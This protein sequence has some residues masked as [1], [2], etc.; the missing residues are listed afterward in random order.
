MVTGSRNTHVILL[1]CR[2]PP[3]SPSLL[4][5]PTPPLLPLPPLPPPAVPK[6]LLGSRPRLGLVAGAASSVVV[7]AVAAAVVPVVA[8]A[9]SS[10]GAV[11]ATER[12]RGLTHVAKVGRAASR[13]A[14]REPYATMGSS[15]WP[16][17]RCA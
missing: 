13:S 3:S 15:A 7:A 8:V 4:D 9:A 17:R 14:T 10:G 11:A 6:P 16:R 5:R 2:S 1:L 12:G